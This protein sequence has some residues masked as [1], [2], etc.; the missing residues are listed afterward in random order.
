MSANGATLQQARSAK[1]KL[2]AALGAR[3]D[4]R[5]IGLTT[6]G[7]GYAVKVNVAAADAAGWLPDCIEDVPIVVAVVGPVKRR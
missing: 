1:E 2:R 6:F 5:G 7:S 3:A 4:L